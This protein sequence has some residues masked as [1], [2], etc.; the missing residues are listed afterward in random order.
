MHFLWNIIQNVILSKNKLCSIN[1][2]NWKFLG[3]NYLA[4]KKRVILRTGY[5]WVYTPSHSRKKNKKTDQIRR[6]LASWGP[7]WGPSSNT[8]DDHSSIVLKGLGALNW[9]P[10]KPRDAIVP[11]GADVTFCQVC[12]TLRKVQSQKQPI[13]TSHWDDGKLTLFNRYFDE[14][15][16]ISSL[17][18]LLKC[19]N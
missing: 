5:L 2:S 6:L 7:N 1:N 19:A 12:V 15:S 8:S 13:R 16:E 11:R 9:A 18:Y 3:G 4:C 14:D 10:I 17:K